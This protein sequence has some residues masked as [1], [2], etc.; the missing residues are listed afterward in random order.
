MSW[1]VCTTLCRSVVEAMTILYLPGLHV[2]WS[3]VNLLR[4]CRTKGSTHVI[5]GRLELVCDW[6]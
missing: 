2:R 1:S 5:L 3:E 4:L 6:F